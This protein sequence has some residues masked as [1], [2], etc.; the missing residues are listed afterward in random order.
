VAF[1]MSDEFNPDRKNPAFLAHFLHETLY[2][3]PE[4]ELGSDQEAVESEGHA[5]FANPEKDKSTEH[6]E[7][8][9]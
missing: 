8:P 9:V 2:Q 7:R 3:V 4:Q 6:T 1:A 5:K